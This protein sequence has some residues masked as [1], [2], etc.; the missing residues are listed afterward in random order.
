MAEAQSIAWKRLSIEATAIVV[1]ILLAFAIDAW[2]DQRQER[3]LE[4]TALIG[5]QSEFQNHR[6]LLVNA[7]AQHESIIRHVSYLM[8]STESGTWNSSRDS[9]DKSIQFLLIPSTTDLGNGV[10]DSLINAGNIGI[11]S[12]EQLRY[13]LSA[14]DSVMD[15]LSDDEYLGRNIVM[16][17][18]IPFLTRL[19]IPYAG[20]QTYTEEKWGN[21]E[22]WSLSSD[23]DSVAR[24]LNDQEFQSILSV[25]FTFLHH[26][27]GEFDGAIDA[28]DSILAKIESELNK[29]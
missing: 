11:I 16:N 26:A 22:N 24:L 23:P 5:L 3:F 2:W 15:E 4:Q 1:S 14:W 8:N 19:G 17:M 21:L 6:A 9:I 13:D 29:Q 10:R 25:R 7:K 12:D 27:T 20:W 28:A 18:I